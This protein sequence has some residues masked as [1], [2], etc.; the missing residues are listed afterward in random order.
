[1][2]KRWSATVAVALV[3]I[4]MTS[5]RQ[6]DVSAVA[7]Q[8]SGPRAEGVFLVEPYLQLGDPK[9]HQP[10]R[11]LTLVWQ[12]A[13]HEADWAVEYQVG[14]DEPWR[15]APKPSYDRIAMPCVTAHRVYH[16]RLD[17]HE[18]QGMAPYRVKRAGQTVFT[19]EAD[20][21]KGADAR[22]RFVA[23]GDC[24]ANTADQKAIAYQTFERHPDFVM[25]PGDIVYG[26]GLISEYLTN[27]W[28]VYNAA[29]ADREVG[30]PLMRTTPF[31]AALGNHD[32]AGRDFA[33][34]PDGLA[35]YLYWDQPRDGA[36]G[37]GETPWRTPLM[38]TEAQTK[39][40][41]AS[42][43][44]HYPVM[45]NFSFDYANSH[46]T[47]LDSNSYVDWTKGALRDWVIQDIAA[48]AKATWRFVAFHH[49]GFN[50]SKA[51]FDN[52]QM[53]LLADVFEAGKVDI[54]F[55]GH[56]H[57]YQRSFPM[58]FIP[59]RDPGGAVVRKGEQVLGRWSLDRAYD[60]Q[61]KTRASGPIY[62]V[63]GAGGNH[64]YNP[65]Q[66]DDPASWQSFTCK[67]ISRSFSFTQVD[68]DGRSLIARQVDPGGNE[69]DRFTLS[70]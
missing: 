6:C 53:R 5:L 41:V 68:V 9:P 45:A 66:Q 58:R 10:T 27:F 19:A 12:T 21:P 54:V 20:A 16:A 64:L 43:G 35:Y 63:T 2:T 33:K 48:A 52:Q 15:S 13:D 1:M 67:F 7:P 49:P 3:T 22:Y 61:T 30:A 51:H 29:R 62:L 42:A 37:Q 25:I 40:F 70:K 46:W 17:L 32:V 50:S 69:L 39:A 23:F 18:T 59:D 57:N 8:S 14:S 31:V 26:R 44:V 24:G 47:V 34:T 36:R 65:E 28:P 38:G 4:G 60:G 11:E 56:V 55:A